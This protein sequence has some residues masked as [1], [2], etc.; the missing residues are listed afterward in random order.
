MRRWAA[1]LLAAAAALALAAPAGAATR[2]QLQDAA[3]AVPTPTAPIRDAV[4]DRTTRAY[5]R[6]ARAGGPLARYPVN[7]GSGNT[8]DVTVSATCSVLCS[9]ADPQTIATFLGSLPHGSEINL[10]SV[11]LVTPAEIAASCGSGAQACYFPGDQAMLINGNDTTAPDGASR[12]YVIAHEYG[13]HMANN[14]NNAPFDNPAVDW[15]PKN[16]ASWAG[17]CPGVRSG[18]FFPG[19][20]GAHYFQ[21][22]GEAFAEAFAH[23]RFPSDPV[24][25]EWPDFP[26]PDTNAY[27]AIQRDA[28]DPWNGPDTAKRRGHFPRKR[29]RPKRKTKQFSTPRDGDLTI[30]LT[31]PDRADLSLKLFAGGQLIARSDGVGSQESASYRICGERSVTAVVRRHGRKLTRFRLTGL[32]P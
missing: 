18:R 11:E 9:A 22:P 13:H 28:H 15:G 21:N 12:E 7:D 4:I 31:G 10:L 26:A 23:N 24:P 5:A 17:V 6:V 1:G 25:W 30:N 27:A 14:R 19:D 3:F 8:V 16:W 32:V 29:K 20:E 2:R